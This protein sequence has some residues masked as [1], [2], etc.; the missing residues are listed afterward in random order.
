MSSAAPTPSNPYRVT[1]AS[2]KAASNPY[3]VTPASSKAASSIRSGHVDAARPSNKRLAHTAFAREPDDDDIHFVGAITAASV[4]A[5]SPLA[6][7]QSLAAYPIHAC[8]TKPPNDARVSSPNNAKAGRSLLFDVA[9]VAPKLVVAPKLLPL[10]D[11]PWGNAHLINMCIHDAFGIATPRDFQV[12]A[13]NHCASNNDTFLVVIRPTADGKSLIP[14]S[15]GL[16]RKGVAIVLVPLH[17]LG[18]DQV[19]KTNNP[20]VGLE[21]YYVDEHKR[22]SATA[23]RKRLLSMTSSEFDENTVILFVSPNAMSEDSKWYKE[24][25]MP[26]AHK[27][28]ISLFCVDEAHH[29]EQSGRSFRTEF[30]D[31]CVNGTKLLRCSPTPFPRI[32]MSASFR[33]SDKSTCTRLLGGMEPNVMHGSLARRGTVFSCHI[34]GQSTKTLKTSALELLK[35]HPTKQQLWYTN[36][37]T[38][39]EGPMLEAADLMLEKHT[40]FGHEPTTCHSFTGGDG[41]MMKST[42]MDAFTSYAKID[43]HNPGKLPKIQILTAT[44]SANCGISSNDLDNALHEGF[45]PSLYELLQE[46]GRVDRKKNATP[47]TCHYQVHISFSSC[48]SLYVRIMSTSDAAER[49]RLHHDMMEVVRLLMNPSV[50]YHTAIE[51]YFEYLPEPDKMPCGSY[52]SACDQTIT[53]STGVIYRRQLMS[54]LATKVNGDTKVTTKIFMKLLKTNK[55][56]IFHADHVPRVRTGQFHALALQLLANGIIDLKIQDVT[57][58]GTDKLTAEHVTIIL[59]NGKDDD[60]LELPAYMMNQS[61]N[62]MTIVESN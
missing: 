6:K 57:K 28:F 36:S 18:S 35:S 23:L 51:T 26:L 13:I 48:I 4:A 22:E 42:T 52:C 30:V 59:P 11:I 61:Y 33:D 58:I 44:S 32:A 49:K 31:A 34:S 7:K 47:G 46:M 8:G 14:L 20:A 24:V 1:P 3:R 60:G 10:A 62:N 21:A 16:L 39:A 15:V 53:K 54:L 19:E 29:I 5:A 40:N 25:F 37:K 9:A 56:T 17:G 45:P 55:T 2:S 12:E 38:K 41:I 27:G 43:G 50:C